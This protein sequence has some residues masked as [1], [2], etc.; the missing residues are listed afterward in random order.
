L[1]ANTAA[2]CN[3]LKAIFVADGRR[4][5][6]HAEK[7]R[8]AVLFLGPSTSLKIPCDETFGGTLNVVST[9]AQAICQV[10]F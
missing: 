4:A 5:G 1:A 8:F 10:G 2:F 3:R 7:S 6:D 9:L